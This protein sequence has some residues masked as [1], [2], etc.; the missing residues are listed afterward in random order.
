ME[1]EI[2]VAVDLCTSRGGLNPAAVGWTR[3]PL[4]RC[5]L[6][7]WGRTKRWE[8]WG[9]LTP[10]HVVGLTISSLDYVGVHGIY[11]LDRRTGVETVHDLVI[12]AARGTVLPVRTGVGRAEVRTKK[13]RIAFEEE[14]EG[15]WL[16]ASAGDLS[17]AVLAVR[18]V[19]HECLGVVVPWSSRRFQY[20]VKDVARPAR[21]RIVVAG[22]TETL[23]EGTSFAVLDHGRGRWPYSVTWN[24]GAGFGVVGGHRVGLQVGGKWT[25]GTGSTENAVFVDGVLHK[26]SEDVMWTYDR[27]DWSRPWLIRG[28]RVDVSFTPFHERVAR[29]NLGLVASEVHQCFGTFAGWACDNV[30]RRVELDGLVGWVEEARNRW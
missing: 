11:V 6:R 8:Y 28:A 18:P 20:T 22:V 24:W 10:G 27:A 25:D 9:I 13:A 29:T 17:V 3:T 14:G 26:I 1:R 23:E 2:T 16:R 7:G 21:G 12:P 30:G 4:H 5:N 19:S 15:T